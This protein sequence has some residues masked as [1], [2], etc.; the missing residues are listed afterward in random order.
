MKKYFFLLVLLIISFSCKKEEKDDSYNY[1][2][3]KLD[4]LS[5]RD[6]S[7]ADG[8]Y[9]EN[10][11]KIKND[12]TKQKRFDSLYKISVSVDSKLKKLD[13]SNHKKVLK[14]RDSVAVLFGIPLKFIREDD[15]KI[16]NDS[17]FK[18]RMELEILNLR[19]YFH[20]MR[21]YDRK[22]PL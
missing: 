6:H 10:Y 12:V 2:F 11:Y 15:N 19:E 8:T 14:F 5:K 9:L 21:I 7:A 13:F 22:A 20:Y 17:V 3:N 16:L 18:I 4:Q 1:L